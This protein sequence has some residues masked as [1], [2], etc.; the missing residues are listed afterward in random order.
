MAITRI[1]EDAIFKGY[2]TYN[3]YTT[4]F[5]SYSSIVVPK[6][7]YII[8]TD[9]SYTPF[10][11][12]QTEFDGELTWRELFAATEYQ[13]KVDGKTSINY[14]TFRNEFKWRWFPDAVSLVILGVALPTNLDE[15]IDPLLF[16]NYFLPEHSAPIKK[17]VFFVCQDQV[18]LTITRNA[19]D[20]QSSVYTLLS[21]KASEKQPPLGVAG[22]NT[23]QSIYM[24]TAAV[25]QSNFIP[26]N[27]SEANGI[28]PL[29]TN[30]D[31]YVTG[32]DQSSIIS[33]FPNNSSYRSMPFYFAPLVEIGYVVIKD[34]HWDKIS[35]SL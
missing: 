26:P 15:A 4:A 1:L 31:N 19:Y 22:L 30:R 17:D 25:T 27:R 10:L 20:I 13:L 34:S 28:A 16:Q 3:K 6:N 35:N 11:N 18:K 12:P 14:M 5:A 8:V 29:T 2:A 21:T 32:L 7:C 33:D 24:Q 23:L 9:I